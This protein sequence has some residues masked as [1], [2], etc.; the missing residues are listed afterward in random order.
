[1]VYCRNIS[2]FKALIFVYLTVFTAISFSATTAPSG[3]TAESHAWDFRQE[4]GNST[5]TDMTAGSLLASIYKGGSTSVAITSND[6][7]VLDGGTTTSHIDLQAWAFGGTFT[8]EAYFTPAASPGGW[9]RIVEVGSTSRNSSGGFAITRWGN[10][11]RL[12]WDGYDADGATS[13]VGFDDDGNSSNGYP[14]FWDGTTSPIHVVITFSGTTATVYK[15]GALFGSAT[16]PLAVANTTRTSHHLGGRADR[17]D[18]DNLYATYHYFRAWS[19]TTLTSSEVSS[20]YSARN[21]IPL[22]SDATAPTATISPADGASGVTANS[23]ITITFDEAILDTSGAAISDPTSLITLKDSNAS[24]TDIA[25]SA[26]IN[27]AKT[28]I[29]INPTSDFSSSQ[30]IYVAIGSVEDAAGNETSSSNATFTAADINAPTMTITA[31]EVSDGGSSDDATLSLTFTSSEATSNFASGDITVTNGAI[32]SFTAVSSTVY[33]A[34]FTPTAA[35]VTTID[36]ASGT[37]TDAAGNN[38]TA[39][40][41]FNWNYGSNPI[42]KPDV[43]GGIKSISNAAINFS[44]ASTKVVT[45]RMAWHRNNKNSTQTSRQGIKISFADPL[46]ESYV[47]GTQSGLGSLSFDEKAAVSALTQVASNADAAASSL[48]EKP[49]EVVMAEMKEIFGTANLNPTAGALVGDWSVWTEGQITVGKVG[50]T[51]TSSNQDS[52][53]FNIAVGMD[54][55]YGDLG[56]M[57]VALNLGKDDVDVGSSGSGIQSNNISL[58]FYNAKTLQNSLGLET[59]VGIGKMSIDTTRIDGS[60]TLTGD[61]DAKMLFGSIALVDEPLKHGSATLTPYARGEWAYIELDSY[62]E[63]GGSLALNYDKQ[64]IN[65]YM[66][67]LGSDVSYGTT[68]ANGKLK[69]FAAFEYGLDLTRDSNVGMNYVGSSTTYSTQLEKTATS[70]VM[71]RLGADYQ[72]KDG[73]TSSVAYERNEALGAGFS[74]ALKLQISVPLH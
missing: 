38:N 51:S 16:L 74:N 11:N 13:V 65:R 53:S 58:S 14:S 42:D 29:T 40:T 35:G 21:A 36:V 19:S 60:Q 26:S 2:F 3:V 33:T 24:G 12:A 4:I 22:G 69:P 32:S 17:G 7:V 25:F 37:F 48:I 27:S 56:L 10:S 31:A 39:A 18:R 54:R 43:I 44:K 63:S 61:R 23:N 66:I 62:A 57:G 68:F 8:F 55:D 30:T 9:A 72:G 6:G 28:I 59:Q 41:Q 34:T 1:M 45:N 64:H 52:D 50:A 5:V 47:N 46:L 49:V 67:F 70:N 73:T 71:V 15:N 20:V